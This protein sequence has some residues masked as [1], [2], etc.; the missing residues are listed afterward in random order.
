[1]KASQRRRAILVS[2]A[3]LF[4]R[5]GFAGTSIADILAATDLEKGGLYNH[6]ASKEELALE[7]F[8]YAFGEVQAYFADALATVESGYARLI[9][10]IDAFERY[11]ERPVVDGGCPLA[12]AALQADDALPLLRE[13]VSAA[14]RALRDAVARNVA[15]AIEK[16]EIPAQT[17]AQA[18]A[19][20]VVAALEGALLLARGLRSRVHVKRV[21]QSLRTM[22]AGMRA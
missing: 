10:F 13:R 20:L 8:E 4:N 21:A 18:L 5:H 17:D 19:D 3:P 6:F 11:A 14:F 9:A 15:R 22:L 12:N 2:A 7:A 16:G 1:M